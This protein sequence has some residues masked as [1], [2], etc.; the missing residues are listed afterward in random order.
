L[1]CTIRERTGR[2][3]TTGRSAIG[4]ST[5]ISF[6]VSVVSCKGCL[7]PVRLHQPAS[8]SPVI[9]VPEAGV[10]PHGLALGERNSN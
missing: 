6:E 10:N 1:P 4:P 5:G 7:R 9:G 2:P 3:G 8:C